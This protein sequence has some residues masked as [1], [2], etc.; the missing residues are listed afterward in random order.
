MHRALEFFPSH[1]IPLGSLL[2]SYKISELSLYTRTVNTIVRM[3]IELNRR[4]KSSEARATFEIES[5]DAVPGGSSAPGQVPKGV[6]S[7]AEPNP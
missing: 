4:S 2:V 1:R 3:D 5:V 7:T 6:K